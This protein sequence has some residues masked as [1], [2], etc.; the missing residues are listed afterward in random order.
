MATFNE[1]VK[2]RLESMNIWFSREFANEEVK[3]FN[4]LVRELRLDVW[5]AYM[6]PDPVRSQWKTC[7]EYKRRAAGLR[8]DL[9][10]MDEVERIVRREMDEEEAIANENIQA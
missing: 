9:K 4:K 1:R 8:D 5:S 7:T 3:I 2:A 6:M 10:R